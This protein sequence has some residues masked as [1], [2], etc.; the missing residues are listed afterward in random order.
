MAKR[1]PKALPDFHLTRTHVKL[2]K[3]AIVCLRMSTKLYVCSAIEF[4]CD[5]PGLSGIKCK[6]KTA[7]RASDDLQKFI[8]RAI[9]GE[10][11]FEDWQ[12]A[13]DVPFGDIRKDRIDW[14][15]YI[16]ENAERF[17]Q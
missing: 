1:F 2:L 15:E 8:R 12:T 16:L 3:Y 6:E 13:K 5:N 7:S 9:K 4:A 14:I 17:E 10:S 11:Y